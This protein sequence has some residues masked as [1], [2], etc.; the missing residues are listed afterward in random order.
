MSNTRRIKQ[1]NTRRIKHFLRI[2]I[3]SPSYEQLNSPD[4]ASATPGSPGSQGSDS[5]SSS[6]HT[7]QVPYQAVNGSPRSRSDSSSSH[8][9]QV[10]CQ[11][12]DSNLE[13][14]SKQ[15]RHASKL[16][17]RL[18]KRT[19]GREH[20]TGSGHIEISNNQEFLASIEENIDL[21][22]R[23]QKSVIEFIRIRLMQIAS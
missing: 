8:T 23:D 17:H 7:L 5:D 19:K 11:A 12:V 21:F 10:P 4:S 6:S 3:T 20:F 16:I 15:F 18:A 22:A 14:N 2:Q 1:S 9:L 13:S